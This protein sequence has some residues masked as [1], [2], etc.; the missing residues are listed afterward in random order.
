MDANTIA[1]MRAK[2]SAVPDLDDRGQRLIQ[3]LRLTLTSGIGPR[4]Q[5]ALLDHFGTPDQ[6]L[7]ASAEIRKQAGSDDA[8]R[9]TARGR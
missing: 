5:Q 6:V 9:E 4:I 1:R 8:E 2:G 3:A 7:A